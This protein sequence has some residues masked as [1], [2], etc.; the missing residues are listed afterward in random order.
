[1]RLY[2][3]SGLPGFRVE[4]IEGRQHHPRPPEQRD[5]QVEHPQAGDLVHYA[6]K[7]GIANE[8]EAQEETRGSRNRLHVC[9]RQ[10]NRFHHPSEIRETLSA[11]GRYRAQLHRE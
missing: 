11:S 7:A 10:R 9:L 8:E 5:G 6:I 1:M 3:D 4:T 2:V